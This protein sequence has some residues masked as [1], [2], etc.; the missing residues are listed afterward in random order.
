MKAVLFHPEAEGQAEMRK[1]NLKL[2]FKRLFDAAIADMI[3]LIKTTPS[4]TA[5]G[6]SAEAME[7]VTN[8]E[9]TARILVRYRRQRILRTR[10]RRQ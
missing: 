10:G 7:S 9:I 2:L 3:E 4:N 8:P 1:S 6:G 5:W